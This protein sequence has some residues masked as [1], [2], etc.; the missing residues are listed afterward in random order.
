[1]L[2][3]AKTL[4]AQRALSHQFQNNTVHKE[5]LA[6]VI[7]RPATDEGEINEPIAPDKQRV[8]AMMIHKRGKPAKTLW[9]VE[10]AF[11]GLSLIRC[12]PK[13][14]KTHQIRVHLKHMGHPLAVDPLYGPESAEDAAAGLMLSKY[15]R[16]YRLGKWAEEK[17]L[18]SRLTLHAEKLTIALPDGQQRTLQA[19]LPKDF[20]ATLNMLRKYAVG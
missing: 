9:K 13:T 16:N 8:C 6:L 19:D 18:I 5:Y 11:R 3:F 12:F 7:G 20:R 4:D 10:Q 2:L 1:M 17:P 15:K 14:G